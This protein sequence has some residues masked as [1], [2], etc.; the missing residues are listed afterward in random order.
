MSNTYTLIDIS[1]YT[2]NKVIGYA[3]FKGAQVGPDQGE[4]VALISGYDFRDTN[5]DGNISFLE[6]AA[7]AFFGSSF[8]GRSEFAVQA[9]RQLHLLTG[10]GRFAQAANLELWS[11]TTDLVAE[12]VSHAWGIEDN[13]VEQLASSVGVPALSSLA[14]SVIGDYIPQFITTAASRELVENLLSSVSL[15]HVP[16]S[17]YTYVATSSNGSSYSGDDADDN[18]YLILDDDEGSQTSFFGGG[19]TDHITLDLTRFDEGLDFHTWGTDGFHI[20]GR[21]TKTVFGEAGGEAFTV[22]CGEGD[23]LF[24]FN[25]GGITEDLVIHGNGGNDNLT[26]GQGNDTI[27][28]G[29]G[30]DYLLGAEGND[31][32]DGGEGVD[33][34]HGGGGGDI[35]QGDAGND[36]LYGDDGDDFLEGGTG[37]DLLDGGAGVDT[38]VYTYASGGVRVLLSKTAAQYTFAAGSDRLLHI[39]NILGSAYDDSLYGGRRRQRALWR[40]GK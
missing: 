9:F 38:A 12:G 25:F 39:E 5:F 29:S 11:L 8:I 15:E 26:G 2:G 4:F 7:D 40:A 21:E 36:R 22:L 31:T 19:G 34:V 3:L 13:L 35:L 17:P 37:K 1:N 28:G 23:D 6:R 18:V 14:Q 33:I 27:D 24:S 20:V 10:D 30:N 32:I 16:A